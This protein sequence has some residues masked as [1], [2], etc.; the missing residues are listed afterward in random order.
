[1]LRWQGSWHLNVL[2]HTKSQQ[3]TS[4]KVY[5]RVVHQLTHYAC[6][7]VTCRTLIRTSCELSLGVP[8]V[9]SRGRQVGDR[10]SPSC[11]CWVADSQVS[12]SKIPTPLQG[13]NIALGCMHLDDSG[14]SVTTPVHHN[15][16]GSN[17][18]AISHVKV[19]ATMLKAGAALIK[20]VMLQSRVN[21]K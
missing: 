7:L 1:M 21:P 8:S 15:R 18:H 6:E 9:P 4:L 3:D 2:A 19:A 12:P 16:C 13:S 5:V 10:E 17:K 14:C 20:G 11:S